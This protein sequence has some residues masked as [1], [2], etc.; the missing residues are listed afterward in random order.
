[1]CLRN[2]KKFVQGETGVAGRGERQMEKRIIP[3]HGNMVTI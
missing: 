1:M 3:K 2:T